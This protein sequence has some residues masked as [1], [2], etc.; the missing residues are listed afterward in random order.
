VFAL[1][2]MDLSCDEPTERGKSRFARVRRLLRRGRGN[3]MAALFWAAQDGEALANSTLED[4]SA[5][6]AQ[7]KDGLAASGGDPE[8]L[9]LEL[10]NLLSALFLKLVNSG[11]YEVAHA[12]TPWLSID[13]D[14]APSRELSDV[15]RDALFCSGVLELQQGGDPALAPQFLFM[16]RRDLSKARR[17]SLPGRNWATLGGQALALLRV[18]ASHKSRSRFSAA[19]KNGRA[20]LS[21]GIAEHRLATRQQG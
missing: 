1:A 5:R 18:L 8:R 19:L 4:E 3:E 7:L 14:D 12:L 15:E 17:H 6:L 21:A 13:Q 16:S 9:P 10:R 20:A 11:Q 2:V